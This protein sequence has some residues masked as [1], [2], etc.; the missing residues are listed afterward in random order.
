MTGKLDADYAGMLADKQLKAHIGTVYTGVQPDEKTK[1]ALFS[2]LKNLG[3][4]FT[5]N[6]YLSNW[7]FGNFT[8]KNTVPLSLIRDPGVTAF[9]AG[10]N[11]DITGFILD[12]G[13]V[14]LQL[15]ESLPLKLNLDGTVK[16][17]ALNIQV[18]G[19]RAD[20][21]RIWDITGLDYV[22]FYGGTLTGDLTIGANR[23]S[24]SL[25]EN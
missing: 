2:R 12:D 5:I 20:V 21:K 10:K 3:E 15:A 24:L 8:G 7:Q 14:S 4:R 25:T 19:I 6:T 18:S 13:V 9:Y 16:K 22:L 1:G 17:D 11:D 23:W